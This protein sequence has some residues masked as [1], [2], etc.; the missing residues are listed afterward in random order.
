MEKF[1]TMLRD[2]ASAGARMCRRL[3]DE[4]DKRA[5]KLSTRCGDVEVD[6]ARLRT[7]SGQ[8]EGRVAKCGRRPRARSAGAAGSTM[9]E[10]KVRQRLGLRKSRPTCLRGFF[11]ACAPNCFSSDPC[12]GDKCSLPL[13][14]AVGNGHPA[15]V[16][17]PHAPG[18]PM[19]EPA[20]ELG[21]EPSVRPLSN[22]SRG[23][24]RRTVHCRSSRRVRQRRERERCQHSPR[25]FDEPPLRASDE[26]Y[27]RSFVCRRHNACI[28]RGSLSQAQRICRWHG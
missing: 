20:F 11:I 3:D 18:P 21:S 4:I 5:N 7:E 24:S 25:H 19:R 23:S 17:R 1:E 22:R 26:K 13:R 12:N 14:L 28:G 9:R 15:N 16:R 27:R 10:F 2:V 8:S 6:L